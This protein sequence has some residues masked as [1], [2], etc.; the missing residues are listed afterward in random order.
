MAT[1]ESRP[2]VAAPP[3]RGSVLRLA[4][5][6]VVR[7]ALLTALLVAVYHRTAATLWHTWTH[8]D[9]Y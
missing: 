8:N 4:P 5:H 7:G 9:D 1:L 2:V 6:L 3:G